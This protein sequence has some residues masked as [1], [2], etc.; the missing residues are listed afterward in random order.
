MD[1]LVFLDYEY[2]GG[3]I[4][5]FGEDELSARKKYEEHKKSIY[6][7]ALLIHGYIMEELRE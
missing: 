1:W 3:S 7:D 2:E 5:N 6:G 4:L